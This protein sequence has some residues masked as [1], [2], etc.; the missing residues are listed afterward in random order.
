VAVVRAASAYERD[1]ADGLARALS[2]L[3]PNDRHT[4]YVGA[5]TRAQ[6]ELFGTLHMDATQLLSTA[7]DDAPWSDLVA[8][9][10]ALDQAD[11]ATADRMALD[12]GKG[13]EAN[14]LRAVRLARLAR[15]ENRLDAADALSQVALDHGTV[16]P[17][18]LV[19]RALVLAARSR[20]ADVGPVLA[21]YPL[22]LGPLANWLGAYAQASSGQA[23]AAKAKV[24][25][26]DPPPDGSIFSA[27]L[28]AAV[29]F[30]AMKEHKRGLPYVKDLLA[31]GSLQP[32]LVS[33]ALTL[34]M[35]RVDH[36]KRRP[37]YE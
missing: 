22:V 33:A 28:V 23:D 37:T 36:G 27:R 4:P 3:R 10:V 25:T 18:V 7:D 8:M 1:D 11:L 21:R 30:G 5:L 20:A 17:R 24:A 13:A 2:A 9:D 26:L 6:G 34:G 12:W 16:T 14:P 31:T 19:E 15:F 32:D 35:K 29:T